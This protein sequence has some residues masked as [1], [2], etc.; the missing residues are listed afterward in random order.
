MTIKPFLSHKR[1]NATPVSELHDTLKIFGAGGWKDTD[2]LEVGQRTR[3]GI[4]RAII[5]ETGGFI[6]WGTRLALDS[7]FMN[8][9]EI[10]AALMRK[11]AEPLYP[12]VPLFIDLD[13]GKAVDLEAIRTALGQPAEAFLACNGLIHQRRERAPTF[14][15]RVADR[16]VRDA[17]KALARRRDGVGDPVAV[18]FRA[19]SE[20]SGEHDLV[21][22]WRALL[23]PETRTL[24]PMASELIIDA[25]RTGRSALQAAFESP[26]VLLDLDLP[27][28]L[29][30]LVGLEWRVTTRLR[31][32]VRQ[33]TGVSFAEIASDGA[34][35]DY[36]QPARSPLAAEGPAVLAV[37]CGD[38]FGDLARDYATAIGACELVALHMPGLLDPPKLR[39]LAR[40]CAR[41]LRSLSARGVEK[42]LLLLGP[43]SLGLFAGA[44][45][46]ASGPVTL[47]FWNGRDYSSRVAVGA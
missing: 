26:S 31:L 19:L 4:R 27:L 10:P 43:V 21:F 39:A 40:S 20:P 38:G 42:H 47:P 41:E 14:R 37:S 23:E 29:A 6:W 36:P 11:D 28:P 8:T 22:D 7:E 35:V 32:A 44:A 5:H 45:A 33:R 9:E 1:E 17:V 16:Y 18:A 25:L 3:E 46:N 30:F 12:I 13:P 2:D 15:R 24:K 34:V